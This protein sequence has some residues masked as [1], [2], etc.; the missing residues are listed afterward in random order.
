MWREEISDEQ[1]AC[2]EPLPPLV[3]LARPYLAHRPVISGIVWVLRTGVP[4]RDVPERFGKWTT[5]V[6]RFRR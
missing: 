3:A 5:V 4:W 2:L 1:W 6:S